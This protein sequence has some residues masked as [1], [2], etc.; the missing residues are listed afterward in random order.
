[1][2]LPA[3]VL[4]E[5]HGRLESLEGAYAR[6]LTDAY[7]VVLGRLVPEA[8][9][10][11]AQMQAKIVAGQALTA[12]QVRQM[13]RYKAFIATA[14]DELS[15]Y[16]AVVENEVRTGQVVFARQGLGDAL[17]LVQ[18]QLPEAVRG[19]VMATFAVMPTA[20]IEALVATLADSS[21]LRTRTLARFGEV[22]AQ[23]IGD[24]LV[25][26]VAL[27]RGPRVTAAEMQRA[28]GV[29]LTDALRIARTEHVRAHRMATMDSYRRNP[30]VVKGWTWAS[31]LIPG[32]TCEACVAMNGTHHSLEETLDDHPNGLCHPGWVL[33]SGPASVAATSRHYDG[34]LVSIRTASGTELTLTPNH[35]VLTLSGWVAGGLLQE[36][37]YVVC[38]VFG[39]NAAASVNKNDYQVP[40]G[41]KEIA[42]S[43]GMVFRE[44]PCA[45]EDFHGDGV[46]SEVYVVRA[47]GLLG[48][49][50][51][52]A[53][54]EPLLQH[55]FC[56]GTSQGARLPCLG[57]SDSLFQGHMAA[58][59]GLLRG[60]KALPQNLNWDL[61]D[62]QTA[63]SRHVSADNAGGDESRLDGGPGDVKVG[64]NGLLGDT[65]AIHLSDLICG[66][67][68]PSR[69]A[70]STSIVAERLIGVRRFEF[71]GHVYSLQTEE[72][73]Y[74]AS[75]SIARNGDMH[76]G[77]IVHNCVALADTVSWAELGVEGVPETAVQVENGEAWFARQSEA[78]Q[79]QMLGPG[80]YEAWA[81][82]TPLSEMVA[83]R[84][85]PDW[86]RSVGVKSLKE[87]GVD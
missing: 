25:Y 62:G 50:L 47:N 41:V 38:G 11:A 3:D 43:F 45:A 14:R 75:D 85:D 12:N 39:E 57:A 72:G 86:G 27:G 10:F 28:W 67:I 31:A 76:N 35:P 55:L 1:M 13:R 7:R 5:I 73:W 87:M 8:E 16:G 68:N 34:E 42:E 9:A 65:G 63:S 24:S 20:A 23:G 36:G 30:H 59:R 54:C 37:N 18:A 80:H 51:N 52:A 48:Y 79:R 53:I 64:C 66:E 58:T 56:G 60:D 46:G 6:R 84:E 19:S 74:I 17:A 81:N 82:G 40:T 4:N 77:V 29:P 61:G 26:G 70:R 71:V 69:I 44:V 83:W 22:A 49:G 33:A 32:R 15:R 2:A 21:P 78:V